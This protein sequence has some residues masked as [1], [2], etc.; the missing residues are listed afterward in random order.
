MGNVRAG[1]IGGISR[2]RWRKEFNA[3]ARRR[4][5]W[6]NWD[7]HAIAVDFCPP[8]PI[9]TPSFPR[10]RES[11]GS[12]TAF[13][14][15]PFPRFRTSTASHS[16]V[17]PAKAGIQKIADGTL[18]TPSSAMRPRA[19]VSG[20]GTLSRRSEPTPTARQNRIQPKRRLRENH[21]GSVAFSARLS[22]LS[23]VFGGCYL[24][25]TTT[26]GA[27]DMEPLFPTALRV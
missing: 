4:K 25:S 6:G 20:E 27:V 26:S 22:P 19:L 11:R 23:G 12:G 16:P 14:R 24:S 10:K 9:S 15:R 18:G 17:I 7:C 2:A 1:R 8:F 5:G 13:A 3:K 21:L